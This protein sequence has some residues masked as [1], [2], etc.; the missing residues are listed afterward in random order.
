MSHDPVKLA[1]ARAELIASRPP[2]DTQERLYWIIAAMELAA[3]AIAEH[4]NSLE[5]AQ[6][7][8]TLLFKCATAAFYD[9]METIH[10]NG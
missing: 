1:A 9:K 3:E 2:A 10:G 6:E 7:G 4:A 8:F 5:D